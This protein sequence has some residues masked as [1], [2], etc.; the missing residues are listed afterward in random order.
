MLLV[1][2]LLESIYYHVKESFE[3]CKFCKSLKTGFLHLFVCDIRLQLSFITP[4]FVHN[5][6]FTKKVLAL[7]FATLKNFSLNGS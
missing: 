5:Y 2:A 6:I 7:K 4:Y 1:T 3:V